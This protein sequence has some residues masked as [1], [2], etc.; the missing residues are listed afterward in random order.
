MSDDGAEGEEGGVV[1]YLIR[2]EPGAEPQRV[3]R[4][5]PWHR[6]AEKQHHPG[7]TDVKKHGSY[8][9]RNFTEKTTRHPKGE[10]EG[11]TGVMGV[12]GLTT[13]NPAHP[14]RQRGPAL[15]EQEE[16]S[17]L[18]ETAVWDIG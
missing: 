16:P 10:V 8:T 15:Q 5:K 11:S 2:N 14:Q 12:H 17:F 1:V 7:I 3:P 4:S 6:V 9:M 13:Y 18:Y